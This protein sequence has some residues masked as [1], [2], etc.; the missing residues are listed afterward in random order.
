MNP[1]KSANAPPARAAAS[2]ANARTSDAPSSNRH[3]SLRRG[4]NAKSIGVPGGARGNARLTARGVNASSEGPA[5]TSTRAGETCSGAPRG[6]VHNRRSGVPGRP[7]HS[8]NVAS[9]VPGGHAHNGVAHE[10]VPAAT[11]ASGGASGAP[12][13]GGATSTA[14][15]GGRVNTAKGFGVPLVPRGGDPFASSEFRPRGVA[16]EP[17]LARNDDRG[18][19]E[20]LGFSAV[21]DDGER[22]APP[23]ALGE[24]TVV[25][26]ASPARLARAEDGK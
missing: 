7:S 17:T 1:H 25:A 15:E 12:S 4:R 8:A 18:V 6:V 10:D 3:A 9:R 23:S 13:E 20:G 16:K 21:S 5:R 2:A 22:A 14:A 19:P 11:S 24:E 26:A